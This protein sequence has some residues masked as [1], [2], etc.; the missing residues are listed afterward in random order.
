MNPM[1][2]PNTGTGGED[3]GG[4]EHYGYWYCEVCGVEVHPIG[5]TLTERHERCGSP[6]FWINPKDSVTV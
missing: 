1:Q 3:F 6:V 4:A 5:V 2:S